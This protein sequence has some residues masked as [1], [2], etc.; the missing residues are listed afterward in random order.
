MFAGG[1]AKGG[2]YDPDT[3]DGFLDIVDVCVA[4]RFTMTRAVN[5]AA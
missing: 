4:A 1:T 2:H 3:T 5:H